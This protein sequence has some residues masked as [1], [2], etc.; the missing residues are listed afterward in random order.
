MSLPSLVVLYDKGAVHP[1]E[2]HVGL[3]QLAQPVFAV[4][5]SEH[6]RRA[7]A[8]IRR[9]GTPVV[10]GSRP[11]QDAK[12]LAEFRPAG[13]VTFSEDMVATT[14]RLAEHLCLPYHSAETTH[15]L[16]NKFAQRRRLC[17]AGVDA[18]RSLLIRSTGDYESAAR[19]VPFP[20]ILK[21]ALGGASRDTHVVSG[22]LGSTDLVA[23]LL[24]RHAGAGLVLEELLV[25]RDVAAGIGDY[26]SVETAVVHGR[27]H[28]LALT[29]KFPLADP[30]REVGQFW[31]A[32]LDEREAAEIVQLVTDGIEALGVQLGITHTEIKLTPSGPRII[33]INGRMGG[34]I[35]EL[36]VRSGVGNFV[37]I[38]GRLAMGECPPLPRANPARV[39]WQYNTPSPRGTARLVANAHADRVMATPGVTR[40]TPYYQSSDVLDTGVMTNP[41]DVIAGES[42]T[43]EAM[44]GQIDRLLDEVVYRLSF[45]DSEKNVTA[46]ELVSL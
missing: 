20:A 32:L 18:T 26:V 15:L 28:H 3:A 27:V 42:Q 33:E 24:A 12:L 38:A 45:D 29:G 41:L 4:G 36:A 25:G 11:D 31:P 2:V 23:T 5:D 14:A 30:F 6:A 34:H 1:V 13:I 21:P 16:R 8:V 9:L 10:L 39:Y 35:N 7:L 17:E 37:E 22:D 44:L 40:Y 46:R 19:Q 43:H